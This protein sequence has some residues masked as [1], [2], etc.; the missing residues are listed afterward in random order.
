MSPELISHS[1]DLSKLQEEGYELSLV[2][3]LLLVHAIPYMNAHREIAFGT[4]VT[5]LDL[6][7][8]RTARPRKHIVHFRGDHPCDKD[9]SKMVSIEHQSKEQS[10]AEGIVVQHS[11]S[12]KPPGGYADYYQKVTR[13]V[14]IIS[15]PVHSIDPSISARTYRLV[16][17]S[18]EESVLQ[19]TDSNSSRAEIDLVSAKLKGQRL[20]I[21]GC[22]GT[23]SYVLDFVSKCPVAEIHVYDKDQF[24]QHNAFRTPGAAA[25]ERLREAPKKVDYLSETYSRIH[26]RIISHPYQIDAATV[27]EL[28]N[29]D[30]VFIC[31]DKAAGKALIVESL[32][33]ADVSYADAGMGVYVVED[34]LL[35]IL[36]V[37]TGTP[38]N[39]G[40][41]REK[42]RINF[43]DNEEDGDYDTNIQ[44]AELNAFIAAMAVMQWKKL[45]G[46]YQDLVGDRHATYT[47]NVD[48]LT[49]DAADT[50]IC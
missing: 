47:I 12:N 38:E 31:V 50:K 28:C 44:I 22:G 8:E 19:Y 29:M 41:A 10:L 26:K 13:Y 30:F 17:S 1:P 27:A 39:K 25:L 9:G 48:M 37:T 46:F 21:V 16:E 32:E 15:A 14:E 49:N 33:E 35:G 23:G 7:G 42:G 4:L 45:S 2:G 6:A 5:T 11:F 24:F 36:R 34:K 18:V 40:E 43:S 3:G 20:A